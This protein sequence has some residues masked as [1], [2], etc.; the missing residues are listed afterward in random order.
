MRALLGVLVVAIC[1]APVVGAVSA[2][3]D[4][5]AEADAADV[6]ITVLVTDDNGD[7]VDEAVVTVSYDG[8]EQAS[9]TFSNG[10]ALFDVPEGADVEVTVTHPDLAF[11]NERSV[12]SV[13]ADTEIPVVMYPKA[14]AEVTVENA[15][16]DPVE[17]A[18]VR[19]EKS[20]EVLPVARILTAANGTVVV[21]DIEAGEYD[22]R[23]TR[24]GFYTKE[25]TMTVSNRAGKT[26]TIESGTVS[27]EFTTIDGH[28]NDSRTLQANV[29]LESDGERI[30]NLST[31]SSGT[32]SVSLDVNTRFQVTVKKP[33]YEDVTYTLRTQESDATATY[34]IVRTPSLTIDP[35]NTQVVTGQSVRVTV[36][37]EYDEPVSGASIQVNGTTVA[38][39]DDAGEALVT[40]EREGDVELSAVQGSLQT[41]VMLT[42][43]A[44]SDGTTETTTETTETTEEPTT[45]APAT[46]TEEISEGIPGF[47]GL[48]AM[49]A[50]VALA[51]ALVVVTRYSER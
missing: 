43:V 18:R 36:V 16:G 11:N 42:G 45:E 27:V 17:G 32:R 34:A 15:A 13:D 40:V 7:P 9:E 30:A 26:V 41:S 8:G 39:T 48:I 5:A 14:T 38:E 21:P 10:K 12:S 49:L 6:T 19:L 28:F 3:T 46:T 20:D 25:E 24:A 51:V 1:L 22:V 31:G 29:V 44:P 33:G 37:D 47:G 2:T 23:V 50:V 4:T 35:A